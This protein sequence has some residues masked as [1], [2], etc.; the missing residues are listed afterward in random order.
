[1]SS[2]L[3]HVGAYNRSL[4]AMTKFGLEGLNK[5]LALDLGSYGIRTVTVSPTKTIVNQSE[6]TKTLN[7]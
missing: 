5:V 3:G 7:D 1:M 6:L 2:Q 4:Y